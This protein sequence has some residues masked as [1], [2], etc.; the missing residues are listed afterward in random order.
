MTADHFLTNFG[1]VAMAPSGVK[2]LR[3]LVLHLAV[4]GRL[5]PRKLGEGEGDASIAEAA[6]L[7]H[8][9]RAKHELRPSGSD[10][11]LAETELE[12][13]V[14]AHWRWERLG[15]IACYI[16]RGKGPI[17]DDA[18]S[19]QVVSQKCIQWSGFNAKV[20]RGLD[21]EAFSKYSTERLLVAGDLL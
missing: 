14:P 2:R 9:Y 6:T 21:D 19:V 16:Q 8:A 15:N 4:S 20:C 1:H 17:Y 5:V 12:F 10:R 3:E 7:K 13:E 11:P 18:G